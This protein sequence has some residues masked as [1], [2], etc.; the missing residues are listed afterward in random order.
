MPKDKAKAK[1]SQLFKCDKCGA[2]FTD[3]EMLEKHM[4]SHTTART[5]GPSGGGET[6]VQ[7][8]PRTPPSSAPPEPTPAVPQT[9]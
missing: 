9:V 5:P 4:K 1:G 3:R 6:V 7:G 8:Q 2:T